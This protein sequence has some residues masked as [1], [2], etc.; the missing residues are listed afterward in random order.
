M[1]RIAFTLI[2]LLTVIAIIAMLASLLLPALGKAKDKAREISCMGNNRQLGLGIASYAGDSNGYWPANWSPYISYTSSS[3]Y[4]E[5]LGCGWWELGLL[6][7]SD[8]IK[9]KWTFFC[10]AGSEN[11]RMIYL[12]DNWDS[13]SHTSIWCLYGLRGINQGYL[14]YKPTGKL[15]RDASLALLSCIFEY[16]PFI[17]YHKMRYPVLFGDM[18][19]TSI[20]VKSDSDIA[21]TY[22]NCSGNT[23]PQYH[24]WNYFDKNR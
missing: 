2:E 20:K 13:P 21:T 7:K 23:V 6:W 15:E 16:N 12:K 5:D 3:L 22:M 10:P 19:V 24:W 8:Y 18:A 1:K 9:N 17:T 4:R 11:G 14:P